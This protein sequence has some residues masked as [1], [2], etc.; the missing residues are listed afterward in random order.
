MLPMERRLWR[1]LRPFPRRHQKARSPPNCDIHS[2]I[3][4]VRSTSTPAVGCPRRGLVAWSVVR[5]DYAPGRTSSAASLCGSCFHK[6]RKSLSQVQERVSHS[7][8]SESRFEPSRVA[9]SASRRH[10]RS[11]ASLGG[12]GE[13]IRT[14]SPRQA[15]FKNWRP[16]RIHA[17]IIWERYLHKFYDQLAI[18]WRS[19]LENERF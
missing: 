10:R 5:F 3:C 9:M 6:R 17:V 12:H 2:T 18:R 14:S 1:P 11:L 8:R 15:V 7:P 13:A 16:A 19:A 4:N